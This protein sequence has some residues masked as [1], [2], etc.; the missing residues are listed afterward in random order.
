MPNTIRHSLVGSP[1]LWTKCCVYEIAEG[2]AWGAAAGL[3]SGMVGE[4]WV[5]TGMEAL[6]SKLLPATFK[7]PQSS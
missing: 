4:F 6:G 3:K 2:A 5:K 7:G 1:Q